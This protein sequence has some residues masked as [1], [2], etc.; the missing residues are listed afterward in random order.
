MWE[1]LEKTIIV[2]GLHYLNMEISTHIGLYGTFDIQFC[3][4]LLPTCFF[5]IFPWQM[6]LMRHTLDMMHCKK[7]ICE[8]FLKTIFGEK[9]I[10]VVQKDL[11]EVGI[12]PE[13]WLRHLVNS[14]S[15]LKPHSPY[16]LTEE[17]KKIFLKIILK[18]KTPTNYVGAL[19]SRVQK[20]GKLRGLKSHDF[21]I[22]ME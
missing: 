13:L 16:V 10:V 11:E 17:E 19:S 8:K 5:V 1:I 9:D 20:D 18:L 15:S 14:G 22:L 4:Y 6:L 21:H 2:Y 12:Q 7:N 3:S